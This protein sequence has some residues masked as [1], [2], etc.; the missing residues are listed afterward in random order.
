MTPAEQQR[1]IR[2]QAR[3]MAAQQRAAEREAARRRREEAAAE[4]R[5]RTEQARSEREKA[6]IVNSV[7]RGVFG[8]LTGRRRW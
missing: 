8:V 4:R 7:V 2:R 5:T 1:E 6:R 3:E